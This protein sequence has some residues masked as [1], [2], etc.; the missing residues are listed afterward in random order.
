MQKF[1][2]LNRQELFGL[3]QNSEPKQPNGNVWPYFIVLTA[4]LVGTI[5]IHN[6]YKKKD[7]LRQLSVDDEKMI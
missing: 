2:Q 6:R 7:V 4:I 3:A 5:I 1:E